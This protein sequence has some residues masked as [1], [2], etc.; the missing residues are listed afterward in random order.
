MIGAHRIG[1]APIIHAGLCDSLGDNINGPSLIA[2]PEWAQGPGR[3]MLYFAHHMGRHIRLATAEHLPGPWLVHQPGVLPLTDTP[4]AQSRPPGPQPDWAM[5]QGVDGLYPHLASPDVHV[6]HEAQ[7]FE[8]WVHGLVEHGDQFSYRA[9][10]A[11]GLN[12]QIQPPRLAADYLRVFQ[13]RGTRFAMARAGLLGRIAPDG[14]F[15]PGGSPIERPIRHVAVA[16]RGTELHVLY[17]CIGDAPERLFHTALDIS[18][19][20]PNWPQ[21]APETEILRPELAWEGADEPIAPSQ[22]GATGFVNQLRDP[23]IFAEGD[24]TWLVYSGGGEAALG[25]ARLTGL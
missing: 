12:W 5:E 11:D 21:S 15:E 14:Q 6:D 19:D 2:R 24:D 22:V 9:T 3:Y 16:V 4:F 23:A 13:V 25:L 1:D 18:G 8:M 20:W 17:S 10:S 7:R